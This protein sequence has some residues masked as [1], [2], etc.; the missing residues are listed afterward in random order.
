MIDLKGADLNLLVSLD[1]LIEEGNVT[2]AAARLNVSQPA[3]SAQLARL[4]D[5]FRDPLLVP[6]KTGRGMIPT[7]RALELRGP[8]H[9]ALKDIETVIKRPPIFDPLT[10]ERAFAIATSDHLT[11][12]LGEGL[13]ER[14]QKV[15]GPGVRVS[16]R[17]P[18][19]DL[20]ATQLERGQVDLLIGDE[21]N[22][23]SGMNSRQVFDDHFLMAQRRD[24]P[25]GTKPLDLKTYCSLSH[26]LV[27]MSGGSFR[28]EIDEQLE[29]IGRKRRVVLSV[30]QFIHAPIFLRITDYVA[31][32][33]A[34]FLNRFS[35]ELDTFELP[36]KSRG[37]TVS[38]CW[39]PRY[40][41]DPA[42]I[43]LREHLVA[44][45]GDIDRQVR[46]A[47]E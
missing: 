7:A 32:L 14:V 36:F 29:E 8:L 19:P 10:V 39:H 18:S 37:F 35:D 41:A 28:G 25:R 16:F 43:W 46:P 9:G 11:V 42:H 5:L 22:V 26:V 13:I 2:K 33:P 31:T 30:H 23:P 1:A 21:R 47:N 15:A 44:A 4:R 17:S 20:I 38:A 34:R 45:A 12:V 6:A 27:S 3:L 40:Q 24:H